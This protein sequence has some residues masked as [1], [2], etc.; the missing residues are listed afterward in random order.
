MA[1]NINNFY[2]LDVG[3]GE[4]HA[5]ARE[6]NYKSEDDNAAAVAASGYFADVEDMLELDDLIYA[7]SSDDRELLYVSGLD[8]VTTTDLVTSSSVVIPDGSIT[9]AKLADSA[10]SGAKVAALGIEAGKYAA[11]SIDT[12]DIANSAITGALINNGSITSSKIQNGTLQAVDL[13]D[14]IGYVVLSH[15][16]PATAATSTAFTVTG[17]L[18]TDGAFAT[19][20]AGFSQPIVGCV[21]TADTVTVHFAAAALVTDTVAIAV[22]RNNT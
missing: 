6:W 1:F 21:C 7:V 14:E 5:V 16:G 22:V 10:V 13:S 8:P 15:S 3:M 2:R 19:M 18:A 12:A 4:G 9:N 20:T 17:T 11:A